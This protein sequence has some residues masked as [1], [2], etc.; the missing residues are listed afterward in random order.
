[1]RGIAGNGFAMV[2]VDRS[3]GSIKKQTNQ[4]TATVNIVSSRCFACV[5]GEGASLQH[6]ALAVRENQS[7]II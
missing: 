2:I 3:D 7:I 5:A 4:V 1:M 6:A